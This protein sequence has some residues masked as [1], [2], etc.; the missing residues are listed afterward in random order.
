MESS[1]CLTMAIGTY[2]PPMI[3]YLQKGFELGLILISELPEHF[4]YSSYAYEM[5]CRSKQ[6]TMVTLVGQ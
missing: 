2:L 3:E 1:I 4:N 5:L 6:N